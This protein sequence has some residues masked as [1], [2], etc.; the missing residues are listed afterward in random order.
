M[1]YIFSLAIKFSKLGFSD[2]SKSQGKPICPKFL[3]CL[4]K[5]F[6]LFGSLSTR[7]LLRPSS[8]H[9]RPVVPE[10][11]KKSSTI[12]SGQERDLTNLRISSIGFCVGCPTRS[13]E[14]PFKRPISQ[15]LVGF[16]PFSILSGFN[17]LSLLYISFVSSSNGILTASKSKKYLL[18]FESQI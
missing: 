3:I 9:T 4:S 18:V 11:A 13:T 17:R 5:Y 2:I 14:F 1:D 16:F 15:T 7:M 8:I 10:P 12:E 6:L